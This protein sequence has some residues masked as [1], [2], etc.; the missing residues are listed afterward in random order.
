MNAYE[1]EARERKA[2][3]IATHV[4]SQPSAASADRSML[5]ALLAGIP[6]GVRETIARRAGQYPPSAQTWTMV[7]RLVAANDKE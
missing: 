3:A 1:T 4:L 6:A 5:A 2:T 7:V